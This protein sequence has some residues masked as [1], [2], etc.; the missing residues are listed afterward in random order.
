MERNVT[1][2]YLTEEISNVAAQLAIGFQERQ[3]VRKIAQRPDYRRNYELISD[4]EQ[5]ESTSLVQQIAKTSLPSADEAETMDS[6]APTPDEIGLSDSIVDSE[7]RE[8]T[9]PE[10]GEPLPPADDEGAY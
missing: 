4:S 2:S 10:P 6:E 8:E 5:K 3:N 7:F 9:R 1:N